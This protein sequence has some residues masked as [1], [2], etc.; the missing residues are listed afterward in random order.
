MPKNKVDCITA[1]ESGCSGIWDT[2]CKKDTDCPF[3]WK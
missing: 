1:D 2:R 3:F